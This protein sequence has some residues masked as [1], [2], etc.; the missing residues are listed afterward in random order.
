MTMKKSQETPPAPADKKTFAAVEVVLTYKCPLCSRVIGEPD[1]YELN[2][3]NKHMLSV[4]EQKAECECGKE[5]TG[6]ALQI[7]KV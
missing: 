6:G 7:A 2:D 3:D 4:D 1:N 5:I